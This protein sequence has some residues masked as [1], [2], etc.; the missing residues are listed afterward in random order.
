MMVVDT[1][2]KMAHFAPCPKT[3]DVSHITEIYFKKVIN[4]HGVPKTILF[5]RDSKFR[6]TLLE[7]F[8]EVIR[9]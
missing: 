4:I 7:E 2:S 8:M 1:F 5:E 6:S 9:H 3:D